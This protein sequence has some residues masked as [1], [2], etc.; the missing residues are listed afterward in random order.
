MAAQ[1]MGKP[2]DRDIIDLNKI[3]KILRDS[4]D[5]KWHF[6]P[7]NRSF[8]EA[9]VF[10]VADSSFANND[11]LKS[12]C[13][14]LLGVT[15]PEVV[16]GSTTLLVLEAYSGSI[17][18][19]CRS[20]LAAECN[21]FLTGIEAADYL[22]AV[23]QELQQPGVQL[24]VLDC[25][26]ARPRLLAFTDAKSLEAALKKDA[27]QPS[28]KRVKILLAQIRQM[29]EDCENTVFW[30][31][32]AQMLADV[33]TK[34]GAEREPLLEALTTCSWRMEASAFAKAC[35]EAIR[36]GRRRRK[37]EAK[38]HGQLRTGVDQQGSTG[39]A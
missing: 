24:L 25:C 34:C 30:V 2:T 14:Y 26:F 28:D 23:L 19:V 31:D 16:D 8:E 6:K 27:G 10:C 20:T 1:Q 11:S 3:V 36:A 33:L 17:K 5:F 32:A 39:M 29:V 4:L 22:R 35:K 12:Q 18:R 9:V 21:G 38:G 13:G 7:T 37:A 15:W